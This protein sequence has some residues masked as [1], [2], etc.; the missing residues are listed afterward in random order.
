MNQDIILKIFY[1]E[2]IPFASKRGVIEIDGIS[3][4]IH[5]NSIVENKEYRTDSHVPLLTINN[6]LEFNKVLIEY[7]MKEYEILKNPIFY[8]KLVDM[9]G[10]SG[11]CYPVLESAAERD[12]N[13]A[14][15]SKRTSQ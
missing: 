5:F 11:S 3:Y 4:N 9:C 12:R 10:L 13:Y 2:I 14:V 1:E 15:C 8:D 6:V 7:V